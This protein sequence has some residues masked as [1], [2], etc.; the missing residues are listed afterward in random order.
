MTGRSHSLFVCEAQIPCCPGSSVRSSFVVSCGLFHNFGR[1][2][3]TVGC[4]IIRGRGDPTRQD[5]VFIMKRIIKEEARNL[6]YPCGYSIPGPVE[7]DR[8]AALIAEINGRLASEERCSKFLFHGTSARALETIAVEGLKPTD[9]DHAIIGENEDLYDLGSFWGDVI[10]AA[11]YAEDT[12]SGRHSDSHPVILA[13]PVSEL[14]RDY[15]L[16]PDGAAIEDPLLPELTRLHEPGVME[17]WRKNNFNLSWKE[18]LRDAGA[19]VAVHDSFIPLS[20]LHVIRTIDD[21][22]ALLDRQITPAVMPS[23]CAP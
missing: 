4:Q 14:E 10:T 6:G 8:W 11:A 7:R 18:S 23:S 3:V 2:Q 1:K 20:D 21:F 19:I 16:F 13:I 17:R 12:V 15:L 5:G 22:E 9:I